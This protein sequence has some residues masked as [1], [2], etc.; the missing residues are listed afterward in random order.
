[1]D[2]RLAS[3]NKRLLAK[4]RSRK[5]SRNTTSSISQELL[6]KKSKTLLLKANREP[7]KLTRVWWLSLRRSS[8]WSKTI[9]VEL[10]LRNRIMSMILQTTTM[11]TKNTQIETN[12]DLTLRTKKVPMK[13]TRKKKRI[14]TAKMNKNMMMMKSQGTQA[15]H[16]SHRRVEER[17][18]ALLRRT[19][20]MSLLSTKLFSIR[21][22]TLYHRSSHHFTVLISLGN[23]L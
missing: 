6:L 5:L 11:I 19:I 10:L 18:S 9:L 20:L 8:I 12:L 16:A 21:V 4:S 7:L 15:N 23:H 2:V 3:S 1:M 14:T 13:K 17:R 22:A